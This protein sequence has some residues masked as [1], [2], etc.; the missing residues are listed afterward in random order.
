MLWITLRELRSSQN[1]TSNILEEMK[2]MSNNF[3][4]DTNLEYI[5][6]KN[7]CISLD[8][9]TI[10][11]SLE[12]LGLASEGRK[13]LQI[14]VMIQRSGTLAWWAWQGSHSWCLY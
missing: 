11:I 7:W 6:N 12:G 5:H 8:F 1:I 10:I 3:F 14:V 4:W 2:E 9:L 13:K